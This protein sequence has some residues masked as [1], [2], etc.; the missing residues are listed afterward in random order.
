MAVTLDD[1]ARA[2]SRPG[3]RLT[4]EGAAHAAVAAIF[5]PDLELLFMRRAH[6]ERDPW[7]GH[8]SFPGGRVEPVDVDPLQGAIRET[9]EELGIVLHPDLLL[10][11][12]DEVPT[13]TPLPRLL[14]RPYV[15]ATDQALDPVPNREVAS[16]HRI[17]V[18]DLLAGAG[19]GS[20]VHPFRGQELVLPCVRFDGVLLWGMTLRMVDDLLHRIDGRGI[21]LDRPTAP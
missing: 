11:E 6:F 12:L 15:F 4:Y 14:V 16:V 20:M 3:T 19:R 9:A 5:T 1:I 18:E 21:G 8:V 7:S 13:V 17:H 10:G 2:A